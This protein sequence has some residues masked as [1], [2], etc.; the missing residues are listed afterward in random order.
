MQARIEEVVDESEVAVPPQ[1]GQNLQQNQVP[2]T[3]G[4]G[5]RMARP[6]SQRSAM[7]NPLS[8]P[9]IRQRDEAQGRRFV[10]IQDPASPHQELGLGG[11]PGLLLPTRS[12]QPNRPEMVAVGNT[13][14][15]NNNF[16]SPD[17]NEIPPPLQ[18]TVLEPRPSPQRQLQRQSPQQPYAPHTN[19][20]IPSSR[21][22]TTEPQ[23]PSPLRRSQPKEPPYSPHHVGIS[24]FAARPHLTGPRPQPSPTHESSRGS[25]PQHSPVTA[26]FRPSQQQQQH[27]AREVNNGGFEA[28]R[29]DMRPPGPPDEIHTLVF[30]QPDLFD[31]ITR[32]VITVNPES[33]PPEWMLMKHSPTH[34]TD[35]FW[36]PPPPRPLAEHG[37][38]IY[39]APLISDEKHTATEPSRRRNP[40]LAVR[41]APSGETTTWL[42]PSVDSGY[43]SAHS[44][45]A[46]LSAASTRESVE[47][48]ARPVWPGLP[49]GKHSPLVGLGISTPM[50]EEAGRGMMLR[51]RSSVP[52]LGRLFRGMWEE[53]GEEGIRDF[54][55]GDRVRRRLGGGVVRREGGLYGRPSSGSSSGGSTGNS[56]QGAG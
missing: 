28:Y 18:H 34:D 21:P 33:Q 44:S 27:Q 38:G 48:G 20:A 1:P 24:S 26:Q 29:P 23:V 15:N 36:H 12:A 4:S 54:V 42:A 53:E 3:N 25:Y 43:G 7:M 51:R 14:R 56:S 41:I 8:I 6:M 35:P 9:Q 31:L 45:L 22:Q 17:T 52:E 46:P 49:C 55:R 47:S 2:A 10:P 30:R 13:I 11:G 16:P 32:G 39:A 50:C 37:L 5:D 19:P 40:D